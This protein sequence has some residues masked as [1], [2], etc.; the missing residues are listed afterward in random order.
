M[1]RLVEYGEILEK[2]KVDLFTKMKEFSDLAT[3]LIE[4][5]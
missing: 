2:C 3:K 5:L 4:N 1:N